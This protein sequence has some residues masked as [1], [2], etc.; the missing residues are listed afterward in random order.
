MNFQMSGDV[1]DES[2]QEIGMMLGAQSIVS[3]S[4]VNMGENYRFRTKAIN[5]ISAA[6][7][8]SSSI[9]V[10]DDP[11][12]K[13]LLSQGKKSSTPQTAVAQ[14]GAQTVPA[15]TPGQGQP[16]APAEVRA[17]KIGETG[18]AGGLIFY[19][20]GNNNNGWRY[21]EAA[22]EEAEFRAVWSVHGT[23]VE[24]TQDSIGNGRR[25]TQLIVEKFRQTS[26]EWDTAAQ[27]A[28]DL[29]FNGFDDWFLP[30]KAEL[31]Q[32]Y[33]NLKR[34]NMGDFKN[35]WYWT[36]T[37]W[38][39]WSANIQSFKDG[40][41]LNNYNQNRKTN[42]YYVRPIRQLAG[43]AATARSSAEPVGTSGT[44]ARSGKKTGIVFTILGVLLL[45]GILGY[46]GYVVATNPQAAPAH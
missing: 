16:A 46:V 22:P 23:L 33:G 24:N 6:I 35:E 12:I 28:D 18:P 30:S 44:T 36:S 39:N 29:E 26:G 19:D 34:K 1:S 5:V 4:L 15:Q 11:Q 37:E 42:R 32:M 7:Q 13:Y 20:K 45:G 3:G 38:S 14:G 41:Q 9:S 31:D 27:K 21:L 43:P 40:E 8:T 17:Y 2:A 25:N 10:S